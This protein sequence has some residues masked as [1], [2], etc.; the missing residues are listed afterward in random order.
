MR[1]ARCSSHNSCIISSIA[2]VRSAVAV[3]ID[4]ESL[5][6]SFDPV[7]APSLLL[8]L[9]IGRVGGCFGLNSDHALITVLKEMTSGCRHC[10]IVDGVGCGNNSFFGS[11]PTNVPGEEEY[12]VRFLATTSNNNRSTFCTISRRISGRAPDAEEPRKEYAAR[13]ELKSTTDWS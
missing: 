4:I 6:L 7:V 2:S 3:A 10:N 13:T 9:E 8:R 12:S 1:F 11:V 5:S